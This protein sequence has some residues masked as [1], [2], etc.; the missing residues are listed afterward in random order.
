MAGFKFRLEVILNL[1]IQFE[2]NAKNELGIAIMR[3]EEEKQKLRNIRD[4][5]EININEFKI[6]C[7]G[8]IQREKI[9]KLK[10]F[11][12]FLDHAKQRQEENVKKQQKNVDKIR[13]KLVEIMKERK[14]LENLK[15]KD[16]HEY[17]KE[18]EKK[19]QQ[20]IDELVS[21]KEAAKVDETS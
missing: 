17:L 11:L 14:V 2:K 5:I 18:E 13:D 15:E 16:F 9:K 6:A 20:L 3:L 12:E 10:F 8:V 7:T 21:Y 4:E 1:K 19:E